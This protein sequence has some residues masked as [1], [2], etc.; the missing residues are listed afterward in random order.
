VGLGAAGV[1][2]LAAGAAWI[3]GAGATTLY[4]WLGA[5]YHDAGALTPLLEALARALGWSAGASDGSLFL[6]HAGG[7][8]QASA[9]WERLAIY[10][11]LLLLAG[12]GGLL[13]IIWI[14]GPRRR[15]AGGPGRRLG[16][17]ALGLLAVAGYLVWRYLALTAL[18]GITRDP[19]VFWQPAAVA[20]STLPLALLLAWVWPLRTPAD[21]AEEAPMPAAR[22]TAAWRYAAVAGLAFVAGLALV[23]WL[24]WPD[25]AREKA[26]R[27]LL[28]EYN[29]NWEWTTEAMDTEWY[30]Q[31]SG[32]NYYSL[33]QWLSYYYEVDTN[34]APRT[35]E[36]LQDYDVLI[37]KTPTAPFTPQ[38]IDAI[39]AWVRAGGGLFLIGDHTNVFG[40]SSHL[41]PLA[42]RFGLR[43]RYDSTYDL[44]TLRV[45]LYEPPAL[46][47]HPVVAHMPPF[48]F[49]TSCT[50]EAPLLADNVMVGYGLRAL[51]VDYSRRV[52][53]PDKEEEQD[54]PFGVFLQSAAVRYGR[55]RVVAHTDST[56][57]SNFTMFI[58][59][60]SEYFLGAVAWLNRA[61][62]WPWFGPG[63]VVVA[64][65]AGAGA[66]W[67][68]WALDQR[69]AALAALGGLI[70][71][72]A[73]GPAVGAWL[74]RTAYPVPAPHTEYTRIAFEREHS[75][76]LLPTQ[77]SPGPSEVTYQTFYV[78]S[79][80]LG[81]VPSFD[82]T[83]EAALDRGD[84]LVLVEPMVPFTPAE[85]DAVVGFVESGGRLL[86]LADPVT[87]AAGSRA[88]AQVLAPFGLGLEARQA[89]TAEIVAPGGTAAN[90]ATRELSVS[91]VVTGGEPLLTL[92]GRAPVAA[93]ARRGDGLVAAVAV[94]RPF[95]DATMGTTATVP[96]AHQ[97]FLYEVEFWL[98]RGLVSGEFPAF[99]VAEGMSP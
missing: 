19:A 73:V 63:L 29:S 66:A 38:E 67:L 51:P 4:W 42:R 41:N 77:P 83:L 17:L 16:R 45:S 37:I 80:R 30:G 50:L 86:V 84:A 97:R 68:A 3:A 85:I 91:G 79:Q 76:M 33:G 5:R 9:T 32:Y 62:R 90:D 22:G 81:Y 92:A 65:A 49:A 78:W 44:P 31:K 60:K 54:Y 40:T 28:D 71:A 56:V 25:P 24:V 88:A 27:V 35:P 59:G 6:P 87:Q 93:V 98:L 20:G 69:R 26:G 94:S 53:F 18:V 36:L 13:V 7:P 99:G 14:L 61:A 15:A 74:N 96:D 82:D 21:A 23:A 1:G 48:L 55:G 39:E 58:A 47:A 11:G 70:L 10:P 64:L 43:F 34:F 72:A 8:V 46:L 12:A 89:A 52:F 57:F 95:A 2:L 75:R